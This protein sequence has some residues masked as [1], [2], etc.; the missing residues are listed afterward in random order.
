MDR[1]IE[2][3]GVFSLMNR[4][5][6]ALFSAEEYRVVE[7]N[8]CFTEWTGAT[9]DRSIFDLFP[10]L[11][12]KRFIKGIT[13]R[14]RFSYP[15]SVTNAR[16]DTLDVNFAFKKIDTKDGEFVFLHGADRSREKEKDAI[17]AR[18]T[19]LLEQRNKEL[20]KLNRQ[21][22]EAHNKLIMSGKLTALGRMAASMISEMEY[23]L[24][25]IMV[26]A[27]LLDEYMHDEETTTMLQAIVESSS[28]VNKIVES[29]R[30]FSHDEA[31]DALKRR[32]VSQLIK[33]TLA[34][35]REQVQ[36]KGVKLELGD[37]PEGVF[38]RCHPTEISQVA[39]NLITNAVEANEIED[40]PWIRLDI[41]PNA[42][43]VV[44]AITDSG[45]ALPPSLADK[46]MQPFFT[47]KDG[48]G[49]GTGLGLTIS[50][51]IVEAHKGTISLDGES[52]NTRF[53]ITLPRAIDDD[54]D[55]DEED[56]DGEFL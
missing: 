1:I 43:T 19:R 25:L 31:R 3:F 42:Q 5:A 45:D 18:A 22:T 2:H 13:K 4:D 55:E 23:P 28:Q 26:N 15:A 56:D 51:K 38:I 21:L 8:P 37:A 11:P 12:A 20:E 16:R 17:L 46:I 27:S 39:L 6:C 14:G 24:Q 9:K 54:G 32:D 44:I 33:D 7:T 10:D 34:L 30:G 53:L 29:L 36:N 49:A 40:D 52:E 50:R 35:C 48:A 41:I 47:T